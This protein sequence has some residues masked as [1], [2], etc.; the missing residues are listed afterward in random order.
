MA[1]VIVLMSTFNGEKYIKE[2]IDSIIEQNYLGSI[3]I[4]IRD[5]GS[6]DQ[7]I[8]IIQNYILP[9]NRS[10]KLV[11]G[12]NKGPQ[13]SFLELINIAEQAKYY[14]YSDQDDIWYCNKVSD[15]VA[16]MENV[17]SPLCYCTNYDIYNSDNGKKR[18]GVIKETP[19]FTPIKSLLY[20]QIPGCAMGF[21]LLLMQILKRI[22]IDNVMMH[23]SMTLSL[24]AA[25]GLVY[26]NK[27]SSILHRIHGNNV[28]GEGHK[29]IVPHKWIVEK[30][31]LVLCKE[32]YDISEM[33]EK[34]M[35]NAKIKRE[36]KG[37][38]CLLR[39]FKK[40]WN[41]TIKLLRHPDTHDVRFD[42]TTMSI[43]AKILLHLF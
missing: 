2:Q 41:N 28:V 4:L 18:I 3:M 31:K 35:Q 37:D 36:Y 21:N 13:R 39:D 25:A 1:D 10:I 38:L 20:N 43:R 9:E 17:S 14:F 42:R 22:Q 34:F 26:Y 11:K 40:S 8:D 23:D 12:S 24:S 7:T 5:D 30:I 19:E 6:T 33:A 15:A 32:D 29:K 27:E 16:A